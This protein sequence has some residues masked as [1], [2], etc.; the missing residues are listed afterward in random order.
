MENR[1]LNTVEAARFLG[2]S[3]SWMNKARCAGDG[4]PFIRLGGRVG[5]IPADLEK[6]R[7]KHRH[8]STSDD[9]HT[10]TSDDGERNGHQ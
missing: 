5:Y 2:V 3:K 7:A 9:G 8:T 6:W 10:S 1:T 4:P